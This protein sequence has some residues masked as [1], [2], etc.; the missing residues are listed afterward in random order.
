MLT[1]AEISA[2]RD[3]ITQM[4]PIRSIEEIKDT[5]RVAQ[6]STRALV[7][8]EE[9]EEEAAMRMACFRSL[10]ERSSSWKREVIRMA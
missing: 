4:E 8:M 2:P 1:R 3:S 7:T 6:N 9:S 5:P 10:P